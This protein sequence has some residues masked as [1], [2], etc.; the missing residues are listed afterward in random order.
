MNQRLRSRSGPATETVNTR[1]KIIRVAE[2]LFGS[3]GYA[4]VSLRTIMTEAEVNIAS[5]H[6]HFGTKEGLLK[7]VLEA[8]AGAINAERARRFDAC[9]PA[10]RGA[11]PELRPIIEAF[12]VPA[13]QALATPGGSDYARLSSM[14]SFDPSDEVRQIVWN[15]YDAISRRFI[16]LLRAACPAVDEEE[17]FW[18]VSC[19][20]GCLLSLRVADG[21]IGQFLPRPGVAPEADRRVEIMVDFVMAGLAAPS[22]A[23]PRQPRAPARKRVRTAA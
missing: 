13:A 22:T 20:F 14:C 23:Q 8:R 4:A 10:T 2:R 17:M 11:R 19:L 3:Q 12:V 21:R 7:A 15:V 9:A 6:Y 1:E 18:R 16:A 5:V